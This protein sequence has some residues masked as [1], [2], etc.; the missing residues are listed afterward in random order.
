MEQKKR[1]Q[2][3]AK[4]PVQAVITFDS[5]FHLRK[6]KIPQ[7]HMKE[8]IWSYFKSRGLSKKESTEKYDEEL[9]RYGIKL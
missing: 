3:M 6:K 1:E 7:H 9:I 5:W 2:S 8:I 4:A